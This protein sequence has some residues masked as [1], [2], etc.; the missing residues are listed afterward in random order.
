MTLEQ[1]ILRDTSVFDP[2]IV[3]NICRQHD[4]AMVALFGSMARAEAIAASDV[5]LL[6]RF[7]KPKGLI[8]TIKLEQ[9]YRASTQ[10]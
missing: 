9:H 5:D 8:D 6:I 7:A 1:G 10:S 2:R 4:V 3:V